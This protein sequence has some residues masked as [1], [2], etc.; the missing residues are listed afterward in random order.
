M[1][2]L[3]YTEIAQGML[4]PDIVSMLTKLH[5]YKI[6][7]EMLVSAKQDVLGS[8]VNIAKI[9][10]IEASNKIEGIFTSGD[11]LEKLVQEKTMPRNRNE[12]EIAGYRDVLQTIHENY[13]YIPVKDNIILQLHRDLYKFGGGDIGGKYKIGDN[14][15]AETDSSG[16]QKVRFQPVPA[17]ET[18]SAMFEICKEYNEVIAMQQIDPLLVIPVF[19]LDFLCVHPFADGNGRMSRLLTLLLLY[20]NGYNV[21]KYISIEKA[22]E[23]TKETYYEVL[24]ES[25]YGWHDGANDYEP[26]V[27]YTLGILLSVYRELEQRIYFVGK[28]EKLKS[29]RVAEVIEHSLGTITKTEIMER[30]PDISQVTVQRALNDLLKSGK[31]IKIGGGRYTEYVWNRDN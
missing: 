9:Q 12:K 16:S 1:K 24:Q 15:I 25:S 6:K 31:I 17:W 4:K 27:S 2:R 22:I 30:C 18:P 10:S 28:K 23:N 19:I 8:L 5:E 29:S 14:I 20:R 3:N 11:R 7:E 26:F 21:G 13:S